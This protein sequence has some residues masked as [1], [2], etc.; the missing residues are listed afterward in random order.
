MPR[1]K[2]IYARKRGCTLFP[3]LVDL[4]NFAH[5][6]YALLYFVLLLDHITHIFRCQFTKQKCC[7][8]L[9]QF[10]TDCIGSGHNDNFWCSQRW[11][12]C[13]NHDDVIQRKHFPRYWPFVRGIHRSPVNSTHKSQ[14]RGALMFSLIWVNNREAGDLRCHRGHYDVIVMWWHFRCNAWQQFQC[15]WLTATG[16]PIT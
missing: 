5:I 11:K 14:W 7:N 15:Q 2:L 6:V 4:K 3:Y 16:N 10:V 9:K 8:F 12:F 1:L 13:Q